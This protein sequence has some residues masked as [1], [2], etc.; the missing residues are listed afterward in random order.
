MAKTSKSITL[1]TAMEVI[2]NFHGIVLFLI[3]LFCVCAKL[4]FCRPG[5]SPPEPLAIST[6]STASTWSLFLVIACDLGTPNYFIN[7]FR[8]PTPI[9]TLV[10]TLSLTW[11]AQQTNGY[12]ERA[13][14]AARV[15]VESVDLRLG[16]FEFQK[17]FFWTVWALSSR[18]PQSLDRT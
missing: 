8:F 6:T 18:T 5:D 13:R 11:N 15:G 7:N 1:E 12:L 16:C 10:T 2:A 3:W 17:T 14:I 4:P 9:Q